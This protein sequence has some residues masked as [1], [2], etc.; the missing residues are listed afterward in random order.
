MRID[1]SQ[2]QGPGV[3]DVWPFLAKEQLFGREIQK[4]ENMNKKKQ[5]R[6]VEENRN[7]ILLLKREFH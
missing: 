3:F 6:G 7:K 5:R 4:K 2:P 1:I